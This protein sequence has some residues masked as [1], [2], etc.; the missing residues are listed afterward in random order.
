M[1]N[2]REDVSDRHSV[3]A[4]TDGLWHVVI[5]RF[6]YRNPT[7]SF[8]ARRKAADQSVR[9]IDP[10]DP[11]RLERRA[12]LFEITCAPS[13]ITQTNQRFDWIIIVD[14]CLPHE[15]RQRLIDQVGGRP[16]TY[17]HEFSPNEDLARSAWLKP[18]APLGVRRLLTTL[19]D[20]DDA[21]PSGF[22]SAMQT[23]IT[24]SGSLPP[25]MTLGAKSCVQWEAIYSP[26]AP[27]GYRSSWHRPNHAMSAGFSLLCESPD[28]DL[29]VFSIDHMLGELW[30]KD[31]PEVAFLER[32]L[33][34][35]RTQAG[36]FFE[37]SREWS[38]SHG[39]GLFVDV[40][41]AAGSVL[42]TNHFFNDEAW[43]LLERKPDRHRVIGNESF[44]HVGLKLE[45]FTEH[46]KLFSKRWNIYTEMLRQV[47]ALSKIR[48][49]QSKVFLAL[50]TTWRFV[51]L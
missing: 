24:E 47:I 45:S 1:L 15:Y 51:L 38:E 28:V 46:A 33:K 22:V 10:L 36:A 34:D 5:T 27:L 20:D 29:I 23:Y 31:G 44:P 8:D 39:I 19:L 9:K 18:Y 32:E 30:D 7:Q 3:D 42:M 49:T 43:R 50:W 48:L 12:R 21:L 26:R 14:K 4:C 11:E 40:S 2:I 6:S 41:P 35:F 16:R 37:K 17:L 13:I 25:V